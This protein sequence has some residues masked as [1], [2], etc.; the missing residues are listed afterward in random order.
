MPGPFDTATFEAS[1]IT[2]LQIPQGGRG[3][4]HFFNP[5]ADVFTITELS[6]G[7]FRILDALVDKSGVEQN[8]VALADESSSG[9]FSFNDAMI[10]GPVTFV[11]HPFDAGEGFT[12]S[13]VFLMSDAGV[14]TFHNFGASASGGVGG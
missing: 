14:A 8:F 9:G 2:D 11:E 5:N 12:P 10:T 6:G 1:T 13:V 4:R 7:S 3:C